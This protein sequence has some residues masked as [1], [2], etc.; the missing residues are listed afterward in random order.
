MHLQTGTQLQGG[1]Y[2]IIRYISSGG[3]GCTYEA[4]RTSFS[5]NARTVAV[6]E[7][8]VKDFC[9]RSKETNCVIVATESKVELV[10]RLK[11][12]FME[13]AEALY[14][15]NHPNIVRVTD[16][17]EENGTAYYV[18]DYIDGCTLASMIDKKGPLPESEALACI[19]QVAEALRYVHSQ[20]RLHLDVKPQNIMIDSRGKA[21]LID[22]GV[23]K[24]YDE[25]NGENTSTLLGCTPGYAPIEQ[26][27]RW[28][29]E[30]R[31]AT[32][33]YSL[34]AT[35]Y[36][37]LTGITPVE[38]TLRASGVKLQPLPGDISPSTVVAVEKA[39][40]LVVGARPQSIGEFLEIVESG[41]MRDES[42][43]LRDESGEVKDDSGEFRDESGKVKDESDGVEDCPPVFRGT[44]VVEGVNDSPP[45]DDGET[46]V[47]NSSGSCHPERSEPSVDARRGQSQGTH[48]HAKKEIIPP[49]GR[50][51]DNGGEVK[52]ESG[53]LKD[54]RKGL[55]GSSK[56]RWAI[57]IAVLVIGAA[58]A[59]IF[60]GGGDK[61]AK[62]ATSVAETFVKG[63]AAYDNGNFEEAVKLYR[64][65]AEQ[66]DAN[67]QYNLG[68]CY[69]YGQGVEQSYSEAAKLFRKAAE[70]G[71]DEAKQ[72][73]EE[74]E[75][76][77]ESERKRKEEYAR[78]HGT[79]N[80]YE[81]VDLGLNVKWATCN[82]GASSPEGYGDYYAWGETTTKSDYSSSTTRNKKM[83]NIA[84]NSTYDVACKK[85][86]DSWRL[87]TKAEFQELIDNCNWV[88]TTVNGVNGY[89]VT[90]KKN[91]NSIFLP[92]AGSRYGTSLDG[93][94]VYG[95]YWSAN[96]Y[97]IWGAY[98]LEFGSGGF[99]NPDWFDRDCGYSV[100]P[101][102]DADEKNVIPSEAPQETVEAWS[103]SEKGKFEQKDAQDGETESAEEHNFEDGNKRDE[104]ASNRLSTR[105]FTVNGVSFKMVAV[106]GGT[107]KMGTTS[108][109]LQYL[110]YD[111]YS[112]DRGKP[113]HNVTLSDYCIGETEVTQ[114]LWQAVMG[115]NPS[116]FPGSNNPVDQVSY[117]DCITFIN[118]LNSL[119]SGQLP[120]GRK[121]RLPT[122]AEWEFAA[123]GGNR[124]QGYPYSG[125]NDPD[126]VA[127]YGDNSNTQT[128]PVKQKQ[129]NE[130]GL[131][132]MSG[133]V[134]EWCYDWYGS[135]SSSS[136]TN[137]KG[138]SFGSGRVQRGGSW[139]EGAWACLVAT[140]THEDPRISYLRF[141]LRLAL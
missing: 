77:E 43:E 80:G 51:N 13:E 32:D 135:Y 58:A 12:K 65:A 7:F 64:E 83:R 113:V 57:I 105:T 137:P 133:N 101:V 3:F 71:L 68:M 118:K 48:K 70:Q 104:N 16:L 116:Y 87:P 115:S 2:E 92:A 99:L 26:G 91:S 100:R 21:V 63:L 89:K 102:S 40:Q 55:G 29:V 139:C 34:G 36:K 72:A 54:E 15:M 88:W 23:S 132:D 109:Q 66:G 140:R 62:S 14:G 33:I 44:S 22:F 127:W 136:Q 131:Y 67:A 81:C 124:S 112:I 60:V 126:C 90:S 11:N 52:D 82:I 121:F 134:W 138:P 4:R 53:K 37:A 41:E 128:H 46:V 19:R 9:N 123:R 31:A 119:L 141:G 129:A 130:L 61:S 95:Y 98:R 69:E 18:M 78:T 125:G 107:F 38:A 49:T 111:G 30:F 35:L 96:P 17:F 10:E 85:W 76:K 106:E 28:L 20:N 84:G 74:L 86:G 75:A 5:N 108:E 27:S 8:F 122:E 24:Q 25:V 117:D 45:T 73:L 79:I 94:G 56:K 120:S 103:V 110:S 97:G 93:K 42:G 50:Q 47:G 6:K 59:F 1:R 39:M 114:A